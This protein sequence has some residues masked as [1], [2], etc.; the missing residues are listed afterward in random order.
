M[1]VA[2]MLNR[3]SARELAEWRILYEIEDEELREAEK[4]R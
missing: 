2:E 4:G 3:I 1:T